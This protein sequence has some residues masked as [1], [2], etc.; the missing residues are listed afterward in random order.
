VSED[1]N[2]PAA[3]PAGD[4]AGSTDDATR[5]GAEARGAELREELA[6][7]EVRRA[8]EDEA[9]AEKAVE[10][11]ER[12]ESDKE[13]KRREAEERRAAAAAEAGEARDQAGGDQVSTRATSTST[14][15]STSTETVEGPEKPELQVAGA[16][17]GA[18]LF[19]RILKKIAD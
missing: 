5:A 8:E 4:T 3:V 11:A 2:K 16:F 13:R 6:V 7:T 14:S 15:T 18:F 10:A 1:P 12:E 17:A 19:A 9:K